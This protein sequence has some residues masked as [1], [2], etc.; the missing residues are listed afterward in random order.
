MF[1]YR[2]TLE[3]LTPGTEAGRLQ[4]ETENHDDIF[5]VVRRMSDRPELDSASAAALA[6][7][8]K[9]FSGVVLQQRSHPLFSP[10]GEALGE[11]MRGLKGRAND[12][13]DR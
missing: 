10:L 1:R 2:V 9:L 5:S 11:F 7:G 12:K 8:L 4:F 13:Q 6:V 3:S